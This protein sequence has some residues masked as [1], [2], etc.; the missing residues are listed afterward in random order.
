ML[1]AAKA[2]VSAMIGEEAANSSN[3]TAF[4]ND[5]I[6]KRIDGRTVFEKS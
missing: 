4:S 5:T 6:K 3:K 2:T 1:P